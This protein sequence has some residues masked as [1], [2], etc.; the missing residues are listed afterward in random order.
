[1][2][3]R[4]HTGIMDALDQKIEK[5]SST[6][7]CQAVYTQHSRLSRIP[8]NLVV[9]MVRFAWKRDIGKKAKIMRRVAFPPELDVL[10]L[11]TDELRDKL[12]PVNKR[13]KEIEKDRAE[14]RKVRKR[15]RTVP[16]ESLGSPVEGLI[17]QAASGMDTSADII[18]PAPAAA[19]SEP[20]TADE[21]AAFAAPQNSSDKGKGRAI[22]GGAL[23][24]ESEYRARELAELE[25]LVPGDIKSDIGSSWTGLYE[26]IGIVTHKGATADSGHYIG[27]VKKRALIPVSVGAEGGKTEKGKLDEEDEDWFKFDDEKVSIFPADKLPS[28]EGGGACSLGACGV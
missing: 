7:N 23:E 14:R 8:V 27:F 22:D 13:L 10:D 9:H 5:F 26:L 11:C 17:E 24:P 4:S 2:L 3:F 12:T 18:V 25:V 6:L 28:L 16:I 1:M 19:G 21:A 20:L 15:T